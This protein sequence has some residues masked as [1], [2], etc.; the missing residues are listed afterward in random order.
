M[1]HRPPSD[2]TS[3]S[4]APSAAASKRFANGRDATR[5]DQDVDSPRPSAARVDG[6]HITQEQVAHTRT[7]AQR[8]LRVVPVPP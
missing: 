7:R 8:P 2:T 5:P 4:P 3:A 6:T 1:T